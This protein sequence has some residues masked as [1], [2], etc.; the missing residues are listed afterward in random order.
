MG[1]QLA[2]GT[3]KGNLLI[4]NKKTLRKV[5]AGWAHPCPHLH[6]D[7][8]HPCPHLHRDWAHPCPHLRQDRGWATRDAPLPPRRRGLSGVGQHRFGGQPLEVL[9][10]PFLT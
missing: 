9:L 10:R 2:I 1:P 4:Y 3:A 5:A 6:R 7:W 8:A